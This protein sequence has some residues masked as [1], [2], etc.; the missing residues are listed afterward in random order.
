MFFLKRFRRLDLL[1]IEILP[2]VQKFKF[3]MFLHLL[4]G[5]GGHQTSKFIKFAGNHSQGHVLNA[6]S[7]LMLGCLILR[8]NM[9]AQI[10]FIVMNW[11]KFLRLT[12]VI[13]FRTMN[14]AVNFNLF[15]V[16]KLLL[17]YFEVIFVFLTS[18]ISLFE[19]EFFRI[20]FLSI[21]W[22]VLIWIE[23]Q[24]SR[25]CKFTG[26]IFING[27]LI[28]QTE[29]VISSISRIWLSLLCYRN[30]NII[31]LVRRYLRWVMM[32]VT[33]IFLFCLFII[34]FLIVVIYACNLFLYVMSKVLYVWMINGVWGVILCG[35]SSRNESFF[36]VIVKCFGSFARCFN[37]F[38]GY[39]T[40]SWKNV[41]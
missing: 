4:C 6:S 2:V 33:R 15:Q 37:D 14:Y 17:E 10:G 35:F 28:R 27:T 8:Q 21:I 39:F 13:E 41:V 24:I 29:I 23:S 9:G 30:S 7:R 3:Y 5:S 22:R 40:S 26:W 31:S 36:R 38:F 18:E 19:V 12:G 34:W 32:T 25:F 16:F 1:L 11:V 20:W